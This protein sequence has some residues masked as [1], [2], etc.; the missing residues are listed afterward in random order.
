MP[1]A[2][3]TNSRCSPLYEPSQQDGIHARVNHP[4]PCINGDN[5]DKKP[6]LQF[7]KQNK[8]ILFQK[9]ESGALTICITYDKWEVACT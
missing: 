7:G 8:H 1:E 2:V 9:S 5:D 4:A 6:P 3:V